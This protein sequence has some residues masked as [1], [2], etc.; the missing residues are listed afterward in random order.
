MKKVTL[1]FF[2]FLPVKT[3]PPN[4][5]VA[6]PWLVDMAGVVPGVIPRVADV[7]NVIR[8]PSVVRVASAWVV[9]IMG[10]VG[11]PIIRRFNIVQPMFEWTC[12]PFY[13]Y[14]PSSVT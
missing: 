10:V 13:K 9:E 12:A 2:N 11:V 3:L 8:V 14:M 6:I 7:A 4:V 1:A 5:F